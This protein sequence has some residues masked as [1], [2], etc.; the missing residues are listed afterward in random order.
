[1]DKAGWTNKEAPPLADCPVL[2]FA[3]HVNK[4]LLLVVT[5][6]LALSC[7]TAQLLDTW[8]VPPNYSGEPYKRLMIVGLGATPEGRGYYENAFV[9][10]LSN[11]DVLS[12][13]SINIIP[14]VGDID[15][16]VVQSWL[17]EF[18][19]DGLIV[20]RVTSSKPPSEYVPLH[21]GLGGWYD[22]WGLESEVVPDDEK[23]F[24]VT[25]LFD[26]RSGELRYS[27]VVEA[28]LKDGRRATTH[29]VIEELAKDMIERGYFPSP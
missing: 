23:F 25:D 12:V 16:E 17:T 8:A 2:W 19:L 10:K 27:G 29:A 28:K 13:A 24:L 11:Y 18:K 22:A 6:L 15:R 14:N 5:S 20:T 9:D 3:L 21:V 26:A 1:M 4:Y 7:Q